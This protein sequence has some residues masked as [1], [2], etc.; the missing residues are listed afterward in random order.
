VLQL[1]IAPLACSEQAED[2]SGRGSSLRSLWL[3][4]PILALGLVAGAVIALNEGR[5]PSGFWANRQGWVTGARIA[6]VSVA[7]VEPIRALVARQLDKRD[8]DR[9]ELV[10]EVLYYT[11][12]RIDEA[13][14]DKLKWH[15]IG[16]HVWE[17]TGPFRWRLFLR[18]VAR[19]RIKSRTEGQGRLRRFHKGEGAVGDCWATHEGGV[20]DASNFPPASKS[21]FETLTEAQ[22]MG[23][24]WEQASRAKGY[25]CIVV[26]PMF[27]DDGTFKGCVSADGPSGTAQTMG[28]LEV[29]KI[30]IQC[31]NLCAE[32]LYE[33]PDR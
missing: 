11:L 21:E 3:R 19:V 1:S 8:R 15:D 25:G 23:F 12:V 10:E 4:V 27:S 14:S 24:S 13:T 17:V 30:I 28:K 32:K 33:S 16:I 22:R 18:R 29:Q 6:L 7:A 5:I 26:A 9:A 31:A 20:W 2:R